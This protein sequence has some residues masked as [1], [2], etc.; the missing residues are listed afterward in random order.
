MIKAKKI[1]KTLGQ[2]EILTDISLELKQGEINILFGSS[3]SGKTTL[4]RSLAL[5][6]NPDKGKLEIF[7]NQYSFPNKAKIE[8]L[9]YPKIGFV[10]QQLFL[11]PH[12]TSKQN[13]LLALG[14]KADEHQNQ[15]KELNELLEIENIIDR[16]PNE[17]SIG[18]KQRVAIARTLILN[19]SFIFLDEITSALDIV[20]TKK[21]GSVLLDLKA[22]GIGV[23][24]ITH[25]IDYFKGIADNFIFLSNGRIEEQ[26]NKSIFTN[27]KSL[28]LNKFLH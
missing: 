1:Y 21:I 3:G 13:I 9:P 19:P 25:N 5:L 2:N 28:E 22:K 26:G 17:I 16:Y 4:C 11:W 7:E 8:N 12:L 15:F 27:P 23:L 10:Y 20:Q 6:D 18:Q 24:M 14:K